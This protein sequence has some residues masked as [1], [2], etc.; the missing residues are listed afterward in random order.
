MCQV[1]SIFSRF[2]TCV[3]FC[4]YSGTSNAVTEDCTLGLYIKDYNLLCAK[5]LLVIIR[6]FFANY[7][8][9]MQAILLYCLLLFGTLEWKSCC[10]F[11]L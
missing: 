9:L 5:E 8:L 11:T 4:T 3:L 10:M 6:T 7:A 2:F 1:F